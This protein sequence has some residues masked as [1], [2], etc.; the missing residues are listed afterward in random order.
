MKALPITVHTLRAATHS[1]I[2]LSKAYRYTKGTW[3]HKVSQALRPFSDR[4]SELTVE[5]GCLAVG[6]LCCS[7]TKIERETPL[8][9]QELHRD[10]PEVARMKVV[11]LRFMWWPGLEKEIEQM[12]KSCQ[13][14]QTT[15][16]YS[17]VAPLHPWI[18][19]WKRV[20]LDFAGPFQGAMFLVAVDTYSKWPEV[21]VL[22]TTTVS[23]ILNVLREWVAHHGIPEHVVTDNGSQFVAEDF[24][25]FTER[26]GI[27]HTK[28]APYHP[29]SNGLVQ[30]LTSPSAGQHVVSIVVQI[31]IGHCA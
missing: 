8:S 1:D 3:P 18:W 24:K 9:L 17:P 11:T 30:H 27:K 10:H 31:H 15:K 5:E 29:A 21:K 7:S 4:R 16:G 19:P 2:L 25:I 23:K 28:S 14:C 22:S 20:H 26:N 6:R 13:A 12:G